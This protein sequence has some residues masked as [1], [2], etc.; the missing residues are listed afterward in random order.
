MK[1]SGTVLQVL[2]NQS[3]QSIN[4]AWSRQNIIIETADDYPKKVCISIWNNRVDISKLEIGNEYIFHCNI[5]SK[6]YKGKW[7]T[8]VTLWK[9]QDAGELFHTHAT[10][11]EGS[12]GKGI[13][14]FGGKLSLDPEKVKSARITKKIDFDRAEDE[15]GVESEMGITE[16]VN[17]LVAPSERGFKGIISQEDLANM[18]EANEEE[19]SDHPSDA[20]VDVNFKGKLKLN[21][22]K[23]KNLKLSR[24]ITNY[25]I[26]G[27]ELNDPDFS[28]AVSSGIERFRPEN[29]AP[30]SSTEL[31][32]DEEP[33]LIDPDW[34][35]V[36]S[37]GSADNL[38]ES[39]RR[40]LKI[41]NPDTSSSKTGDIGEPKPDFIL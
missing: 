16:S 33:E 21:P 5:E 24:K 34:D 25:K 31:K 15:E 36:V 30:P 26:E 28:K 9:I 3:G 29:S 2:V 4:G 40:H 6:E 14:V 32:F 41:D 37:S 1:I 10:D 38:P 19:S 27:G 17:T 39:L 11:N 18:M 35:K 13:S 8:E 23:I 12:A 22:E 20:S 7:Y